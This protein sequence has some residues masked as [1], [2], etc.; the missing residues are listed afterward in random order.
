[1][2][3]AMKSK[4]LVLI[5]GVASLALA[6]TAAFANK[7]LGPLYNQ[8]YQ[9]NGI[10]STDFSSDGQ[11]ALSAESIDTINCS[12]CDTVWYGPGTVFHLRNVG[13][14]PICASFTFTPRSSDYGLHQWGS[15]TAYYIKA[16]KQAYQ[17]GG[18]FYISTGQTGSADLGYTGSIRTWRPVAKNDCGAAANR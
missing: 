1:M 10:V 17:A 4:N 7:G 15:G 11:V 5:A 12:G 6:G 18:I 8:K 16:G 3:R 9:S 2:G 14:T 13:K